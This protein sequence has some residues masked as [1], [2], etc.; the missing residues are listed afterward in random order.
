[1]LKHLETLVISGCSNLNGLQKNMEYMES[2][3]VLKADGIALT[4]SLPTNG[5]VNAVQS[6]IW[7]WQL[8]PR[9]NSK[10][11]WLS[12]PQSLVKLS[13]S[14]CN[15]SDDEFPRDLSNLYSLEELDLSSNQ[16]CSLPAFIRG[17]T[18]LES[19]YILSC[20]RLRKL[21]GVPQLGHIYFGGNRLL[22]ELTF[23]I[24][25]QPTTTC[26]GDTCNIHNATIKRF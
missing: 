3:I 6:F 4:H 25:H 21:D 7:P 15:L 14:K 11:S 8:K 10:I 13:L 26:H 17:L 20:P 9:E 5:Q 16:F 23:Q 22:E 18:K 12:L 1:M 24:S 19:L 2:L